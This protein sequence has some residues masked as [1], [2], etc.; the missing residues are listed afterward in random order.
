MPA[1][2]FVGLVLVQ[3]TRAQEPIRTR[4]TLAFSH[5]PYV[6]L[7][8]LAKKA[9][10][11]EQDWHVL[12]DQ[13]L[14]ANPPDY[15]P[16]HFKTGV[17]LHL[18]VVYARALQLLKRRAEWPDFVWQRVIRILNSPGHALRFHL[19]AS[20]G[21]QTT[22]PIEV[23]ALASQLR[24]PRALEMPLFEIQKSEYPNV[25]IEKSIL[26]R[27]QLNSRF[28]ELP[29]VEKMF[30]HLANVM[31][32]AIAR[33]PWGEEKAKQLGLDRFISNGV[34]NSLSADTDYILTGFSKPNVWTRIFKLY[35]QKQISLN[36]L[37][38]GA[39]RSGEWPQQ[40]WQLLG[41]ELVSDD[42]QRMREALWA[43]A[44]CP[45]LLENWDSGIWEP[46]MSAIKNTR[47]SLRD[48]DFASFRQKFQSGSLPDAAWGAIELA[49]QEQNGLAIKNTLSLIAG[50]RFW[51]AKVKE[52]F[53]ELYR[54]HKISASEAFSLIQETQ[55]W[56][57]LI[58]ADVAAN[59]LF[60]EASVEW[61]EAISHQDYWPPSFAL[62]LTHLL[63]DKTSRWRSRRGELLELLFRPRVWSPDLEARVREIALDA[64]E[65]KELR[66]KAMRALR[67][68]EPLPDHGVRALGT[69]ESIF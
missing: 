39:I 41:A 57:N 47:V 17:A 1:F 8:D 21:F 27:L 5:Q 66:K 67:A 60:F 4:E 61:L 43:L 33:V 9:T 35:E 62:L 51:P 58:W 40:M 65:P 7:D 6:D 23:W 28:S 25:G 68:R 10:W 18:P 26:D 3:C 15:I 34:D 63:S 22:W 53:T 48:E 2:I 31:W 42:Y 36:E 16:T 20:L 12:I 55:S 49:L 64:A 11:T 44:F 50:Q 69:C 24:E 37:Y 32:R 52:E 13:Y 30:P 38:R 59:L 19:A 29:Y 46:L 14:P 56:P 54:N 45:I